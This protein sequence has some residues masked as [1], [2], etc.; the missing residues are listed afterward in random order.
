MSLPRALSILPRALAWAAALALAAPLAFGVS[1]PPEVLELPE[2]VVRGIDRVRLDAQRAGVLPLEAPRLAQAPIRLDLATDALPAPALTAAPPVQSP[3]CAYRNPVTGAL[4]RATGGAEALYKTALERFSRDLL[5][6]AAAYLAQLRAD[7]PQNPR[8]DDAAF[9]LAEVRRRQG[10]PDEAV[11]FLRLV[12]GSYAG[13][14]AYRLAWLLSD[15]GR[16]EEARQAWDA[17]A[18]DASGPHRY[19]ALYRLGADRLSAG[20]PQAAL[21]PLERLFALQ[22]EGQ[23]VPPEVRAADLLALGLARRALGDHRAA[24]NALVRFL[25]ENPDHSA[26]AAAQVALAWTLLDQGKAREAAQRFAWIVDAGLGPEL[27]APSLYGRVRALAEQE[28]AG[29]ADALLALEAGAPRGPWAGWARADLGWLAF[30]QKRYEE[31]LARYRAALQAWDAPGA[32]VPQYMAGESLYLL[33][34]YEEAAAAYRAVPAET[35]LGPAALHRAGLCEL[36]A[37]RPT[38]AAALLEEVLR[39]DPGYPQADRVWAWLGEARLRLGQRP[40]ALRAFNAVPERSPAHSQALY[41]R[42]WVAF[43][44][45]R[46]DEA[47]DL[48]ARFL[49]AYPDD[50]NRDE[51]RLNL[52]RAHFNRRELKPA[53]D[54]LDR[55]EAETAAPFYRSAARFYRAWMFA[56]SGREAQARTLLSELLA[57]APDGPFAARAHHSLGWLEFGAG[58]YAEAL[59]QF[60]ASLSRD[61]SGALAAEARQK[62]ADCLYNL[63]RHAEALDAYRALGET[64]EGR[65]GVALSLFRLGRLEDLARAAEDFAGRYGDDPRGAD[66]FLALAQARSDAADPAGAAAAYQRAA[67]LAKTGD[68]AAEARLEAARSL[69]RAGQAPRALELLEPLSR[70]PGPLGLAALRE[71]ARFFEEQGPPARARDAWDQVARRTDGEERCRARRDAARSARALLDWPGAEERLRAAFGACPPSAQLLRQGVLADLGELFLLAGTPDRA[72]APLA[73]AGEMGTSPEGLRA[74]QALGRAQEAAGR[75]Q[76]AL[77]T[78]L[79]IGYLYPLTDAEAARALL[80]AGSLLEAQGAPDRA[81]AVYE[82]VVSDAGEE[83]A[84]EAQ[85]LLDRLPAPP[86]R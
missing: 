23:P 70:E 43:D 65:Y 11:A 9:W 10:K 80:R 78:Y 52:A 8:A 67:A 48:F 33:G 62:R 75:G 59:A 36:L 63:G 24:E 85:E 64:P 31:A 28:D 39:R 34:R 73:E 27:L 4:A 45:E 49:R 42:A 76:E 56:R 54:A 19:E 26:A 22:E 58:R 84:R 21:A 17:L 29:A 20:D 16:T 32:A 60:D 30:R 79:R 40:E 57:A 25:L 44:T 71:L 15:R 47:A 7:H 77:E 13:E 51:A 14:A 81:R 66:L 83:P 41:G 69:L 38:E 1:P 86:T 50:A 53:L 3:G 12:R 46:W 18:Q 61:P 68:R 74:Y 5:D 37:G 35:G 82:K 72:L 2:V 55:L 6:E